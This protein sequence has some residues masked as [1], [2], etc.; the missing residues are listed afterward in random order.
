MKLHF[1]T[2]C[3]GPNAANRLSRIAI[4]HGLLGSSQ[5]WS[6]VAVKLGKHPLIEDRLHSLYTLD[7]R[8]HGL[9]PHAPENTNALMAT[10]VEQF[11]IDHMLQPAPRDGD[12]GFASGK[13]VL[14]G[15]SMGG[16][17]TMAS[18]Y[19]RWN[20]SALRSVSHSSRTL[21]DAQ[22][23]VAAMDLVPQGKRLLDP[24]EEGSIA[25]AVIVDITP[26]TER[27][28][29]FDTVQ[30]D[31]EAM[32]R[33]DLSAIKSTGDGVSMLA[34]L[35]VESSQMR[36]FLLTNLQRREDGT[37]GWK[38]NLGVLCKDFERMLLSID[39]TKCLEH[40]CDVRKCPIPVLFV[41]GSKSPYNNVA[42]R[43][44]IHKYFSNVEEVVIEG[45]GHFVHYEKMNE[46]VDAVAPFVYE[47]MGM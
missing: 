24:A 11:A 36:N 44:R 22:D 4:S 14:I 25:A 20:E 5:N 29:T 7:L 33:M 27:P 15:H 40:G 17:V 42:G 28:S 8:N 39:P 18:L 16:L 35:G 21:F 6:T 12:L 43:E 10:D 47:H 31:I 37:F 19:R 9:S 46:F 34:N 1:Q 2:V 13:S 45:A 38:C 30:R 3:R 26:N 32:K 23:H 41:F